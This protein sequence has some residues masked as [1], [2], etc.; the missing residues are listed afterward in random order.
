MD[1][2]KKIKEYFERI[3]WALMMAPIGVVVLFYCSPVLIIF[4][5][6]IVI[7]YDI[8]YKNV[9]HIE[10]NQDREQKA[11]SWVESNI[12]SKY[13]IEPVTISEDHYNSHPVLMGWNYR[14]MRKSDYVAF[15][16]MWA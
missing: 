4:F 8:V 14:F 1:I 7:K 11:K 9:Y 2:K 16:L 13:V 6:F 3:F 5:I 10:Y 12:K 15:K